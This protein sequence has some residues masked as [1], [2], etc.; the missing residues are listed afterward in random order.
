MDAAPDPVKPGGAEAAVELFGVEFNVVEIV[1]ERLFADELVDRLERLLRLGGQ[2]LVG[3]R[4][5]TTFAKPA[6]SCRG[7]MPASVVLS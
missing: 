3:Q 6:W 1:L 7:V 5:L 4:Q 2:G